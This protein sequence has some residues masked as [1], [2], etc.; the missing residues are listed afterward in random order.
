MFCLLHT[1]QE[2]AAQRNFGQEL[3]FSHYFS[4][5]EP[6]TLF[7]SPQRKGS[8]LQDPPPSNQLP[9]GVKID[10]AKSGFEHDFGLRQHRQGHHDGGEKKAVMTMT[11][12]MTMMQHDATT[13]QIGYNATCSATQHTLNTIKRRRAKWVENDGNRERRP[14]MRP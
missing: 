12:V 8:F 11:M 14:S 2:C 1:Q 5:I 9:L 3:M 6:S 13:N 7:P 4:C 10:A